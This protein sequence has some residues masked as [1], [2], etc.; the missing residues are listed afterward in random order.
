MNYNF[1]YWGPFLFKTKILEEEVKKILSFC[2][3]DEKL[4]F[5][6]K[7]AG[8]LK[9]EYLLNNEDI[10][11][12]LFP[13]METY[14][15]TRYEQWNKPFEGTIEMQKVWVNYMKQGEFNPPH[16]HDSDLSCVL[17]LQI[18][19]DIVKNR[20]DHV[21]NSG[22]PGSITFNYGENLSNNNFTYSFFPEIGDFFIFPAWLEHYVFP[23]KSTE[24]RISLSAN[25]KE[26]KNP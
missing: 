22:V 14:V 1:Y 20:E 23:F 15:K 13:Y 19:K 5:R 4:D 17:Y 11:P 8:H 6:H 21:A 26:I 2:K 16:I 3:R 7:L 10:F 12:I 9:E 25:F 18:P 24:E